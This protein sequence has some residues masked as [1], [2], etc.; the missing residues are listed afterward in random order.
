MKSPP[1][2]TE[3]ARTSARKRNGLDLLHSTFGGASEVSCPRAN[4][5]KAK[6][7]AHD[8]YGNRMDIHNGERRDVS[9]YE[10][11]AVIIN[12]L[13]KSDVLKASRV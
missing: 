13:I 1:I 4:T 9:Y 3:W 2:G 5:Q 10:D 11:N 7:T 8:V 12:M 6:S